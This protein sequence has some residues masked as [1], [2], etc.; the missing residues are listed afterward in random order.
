MTATMLLVVAAAIVVW[1]I[2][3]HLY[4]PSH[5]PNEPPLVSHSIPYIGHIIGLLRYGTRYYEIIRYFQQSLLQV[6]TI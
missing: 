4:I 2:L 1:Y 6:C 5:L 3:D